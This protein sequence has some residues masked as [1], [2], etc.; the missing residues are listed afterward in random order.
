[1]KRKIALPIIIFT[2]GIQAI[3]AC[4][5]TARST[6]PG[7]EGI[8]PVDPFFEEYYDQLG[9]KEIFGPAISP[10]FQQNGSRYQYTVAG[11]LMHDPTSFDSQ[12]FQLASL[13][14]ELGIYEFPSPQSDSL[15]G[16][17]IN[18]HTVYPEFEDLIDRIGGIEV[19]GNPLTEV[20][21]NE[22][23]QR[24][25]QYFENIGFY[26]IVDDPD[27]SVYLLA[28]GAWMCN[29]SCS[30]SAP[31][32]G[33]IELPFRK[34][35]TFIK[36]VKELGTDYTGFALTEP[37]LATD[38]NLEQIFENV[39]LI[40]NPEYPDVIF[41][42]P[43]PELLGI[44]PDPLEAP[45]DDP[46]FDFYTIQ[47]GLGYN[48]PKRFNHYL[49]ARGGMQVAGP[50]ITRPNILEEKNLVQ[51]FTQICLEEKTDSIGVLRI[52]PVALGYQ[53][54]ENYFQS[55]T[56]QPAANA[57]QEI[58]IQVWE[59]FPMVSPD[60][61]QEIGVGVYSGNE[62]LANVQ[63][64]L[65]LTMPDGREISFELPFTGENGETHLRLKPIR[66]QNGTL[67]PYQVCLSDP[68]SKR[69]CVQDSYLIWD[70]TTLDKPN[71]QYLPAIYNY[72]VNQVDLMA[73]KIIYLPLVVR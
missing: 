40:S 32:N 54:R 43:L 39:V 42:R 27:K 41:L 51:C 12:T 44:S 18:G 25:E 11:L 63:P 55:A 35:T 47:D 21:L 37:F 34:A 10:M 28:Y 2:L 46:N 57:Y 48:V 69:F 66:S 56:D 6:K 62:P 23:K 45:V 22:E 31:K 38:G 13:G 68:T 64:E 58:S 20:R 17:Y 60:K 19:V 4:T 50:P 26:Q 15:M 72:I 33:L 9:G 70:T 24:F 61:E 65:L 14:V 59:T 7:L 29:Q 52:H 1:M 71:V 16:R 8:Y 30:Y 3:A 73:T 67:I 36:F 53:Y 49:A 5:D